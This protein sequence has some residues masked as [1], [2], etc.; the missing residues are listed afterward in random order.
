MRKAVRMRHTRLPRCKDE[1][2][3]RPVK[4][5]IFR[6][7]DRFSDLKRNEKACAFLHCMPK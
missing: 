1:L 5:A 2:T 7:A 6:C 4:S 3:R